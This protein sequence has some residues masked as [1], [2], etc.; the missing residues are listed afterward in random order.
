VELNSGC[1]TSGLPN[2]VEDW[3]TDSHDAGST[4]HI[5]SSFFDVVV[6]AHAVQMADT[7]TPSD[8]MH[9]VEYVVL[10]TI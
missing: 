10:R 9:E 2:L 3:M 8:P 1:L 6:V 5:C 4:R 7:A